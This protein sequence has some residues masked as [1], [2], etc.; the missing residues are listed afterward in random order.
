MTALETLGLFCPL[1][2]D[3]YQRTVR[4]LHGVD[5]MAAIL[6]NNI[7]IKYMLRH[8]LSDEFGDCDWIREIRVT[9]LNM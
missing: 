6:F 8:Q 9:I 7:I 1:D 4:N 2:G 5:F 3:L